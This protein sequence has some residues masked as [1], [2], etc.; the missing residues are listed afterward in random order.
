M[1]LDH[2]QTSFNNRAIVFEVLVEASEREDIPVHMR[3]N[4]KQKFEHIAGQYPLVKE[5]KDRLK[6]EIDY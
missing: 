6:L 2:L 5:L 1:L 3:L 4:S